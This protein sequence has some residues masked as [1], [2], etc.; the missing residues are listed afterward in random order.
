V[1]PGTGPPTPPPGP[2]KER[3]GRLAFEFVSVMRL[4]KVPKPSL[5]PVRPITSIR[6]NDRRPNAARGDVHALRNR[7]M[8]EA[9][10]L[11]ARAWI[12]AGIGVGL[13]I[14]CLDA[15][16]QSDVNIRRLPALRG[17]CQEGTCCS[18]A[19]SCFS[20][21][22]LADNKPV[23]ATGCFGS[24]S[25]G[26]ALSTKATGRGQAN[27]HHETERCASRGHCASWLQVANG[28]RSRVGAHGVS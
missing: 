17:L 28:G 25:P 16:A 3:L 24:A 21:T 5:L 2:V 8:A 15:E 9:T 6:P 22:F 10:T 20:V 26:V 7:P 14:G 1:S 4:R 11:G 12:G 19:S 27:T 23:A 18:R 13:G